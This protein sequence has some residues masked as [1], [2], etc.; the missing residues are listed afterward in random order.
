MHMNDSITRITGLTDRERKLV[1]LWRARLPEAKAIQI[2][3]DGMQIYFKLKETNEELSG[4]LNRY[5]AIILS[6][7]RSGW[8]STSGKGYRVAEKK[9]FEDFSSLRRAKVAEFVRRGRTP[10]KRKKI[11]SHWGEIVEMKNEGYGFRAIAAYLTKNRKLKTS[12]SYLTKIWNE[13]NEVKT[14]G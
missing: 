7:R 11:M 4:R 2:L 10:I 14:D 5:C 3:Q 8:D 13:Q 9:Q 1:L 6:A 12:A